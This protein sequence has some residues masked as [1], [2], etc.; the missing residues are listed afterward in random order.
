MGG[1][2]ASGE[3]FDFNDIFNNGPGSRRSKVK[4]KTKSVLH[5]IEIPLEDMYKG[6]KKTIEISRHKIC[7]T[8]SG[9]GSKIKDAKTKCMGC[10]GTGAK[11]KQ[12]QTMMGIMQQSVVCNDCNGEGTLI[13]EKD[14]C[15]SCKGKKTTIQKKQLDLDM[16][17]GIYDGKR[18]IFKGEADE[19]PGVEAGDLYIEILQ[20][21]NNLFQR[22]G[23]DL[24]YKMS[25]TLMEALT[26]FKKT[27]DFIDGTKV[28]IV[29]GPDNI[30]KPGIYNT[31]NL[32]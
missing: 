25:I 15:T 21:K 7:T 31:I 11:V 24:V 27:I 26:G 20:K 10:N 4:Q 29:N 12:T 1:A 32:Y 30:I 5:Q 19:F 17:K 18:I 14:K 8:C 3:P 9:T 2:G 22:K 6:S 23:A 28:L 13:K 16:E